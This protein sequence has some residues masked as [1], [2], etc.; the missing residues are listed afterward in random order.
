[1]P[2]CLWGNKLKDLITIIDSVILIGILLLSV[3]I[4]LSKSIIKGIDKRKNR[5]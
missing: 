1:M 4:V 3:W 2:S 5:N